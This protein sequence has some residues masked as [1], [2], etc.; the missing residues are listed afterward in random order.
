HGRGGCHAPVGANN[1][2][3]SAADHAVAGRVA[4]GETAGFDRLPPVAAD[5][6]QVRAADHAVAVEIACQ[7]NRTK[8]VAVNV[9]AL[10]GHAEIVQFDVART[11]LAVVEPEVV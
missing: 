10:A 8:V 7:R 1:I 4:T 11:L 6:V 3:I 2:Q 5:D 9:V